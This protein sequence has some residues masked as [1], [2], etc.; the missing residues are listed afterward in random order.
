MVSTRSVCM[1]MHVS[2]MHTVTAYGRWGS[3]QGEDQSAEQMQNTS[4]QHRSTT[5]VCGPAHTWGCRGW[6]GCKPHGLH[7]LCKSTPRGARLLPV[8]LLLLCLQ[9]GGKTMLQCSYRSLLMTAM[10][11]VQLL[12]FCWWCC[13]RIHGYPWLYCSTPPPFPMKRVCMHAW[14]PPTVGAGLARLVRAWAT[15]RVHAGECT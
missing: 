3:Y 13:C 4:L 15:C 9:R 8:L 7:H 11:H 2:S 6:S 10:Q 5:H 12:C 1:R 14:T